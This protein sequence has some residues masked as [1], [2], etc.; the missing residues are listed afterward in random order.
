MIASAKKLFDISPEVEAALVSRTPIVALESSFLTHGIPYP[1][2]IAAVVA[3]EGVVRSAGAT[4]ATIAVLSGRIKIGLSRDE[5][6]QL[7]GM[8]NVVKTGRAEL[9][10]VVTAKLHGSTTVASTIICSSFVNIPVFA[11]GGIGGV[12]R[13]VS[14]TL[15]ISSDLDEI[16]R[17]PTTVVCSGAK[18]ILDIPKT[19]E[20][21]E[22]RGVPVIGYG[23]ESFPA[24][25]SRESGVKAP[26]RLDTVESLAEFIAAKDALGL[27]GGILV[28][29]P[30]AASDEVPW[31]ELQSVID[32]ALDR[33]V[34]RGIS[35][36]AI[37]PFLLR[38]IDELTYG[39]TNDAA[40]T[41]LKNNAQLAALLASAL[42]KTAKYR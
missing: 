17:L 12:H 10:Y 2:N 38:E 25:W 4:P 41:L 20:Y 42:I 18:A 19:L 22:T 24:F 32:A 30:I 26:I 29:N 11:T 23:T 1:K 16:A 3:I 28:A 27:S 37:T 34:K 39:R 8:K 7:G 35:G 6:E 36:K 9:P 13:G 31:G 14:E 40:E 15:D 5:V 33:A 21:L